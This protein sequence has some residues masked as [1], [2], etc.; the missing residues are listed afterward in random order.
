M[1][2]ISSA[3]R[4]AI[5][6]YLYISPWLIGFLVFAAGPMLVSLFLSLTIYKIITPPD[7]IGVANYVRMFTDDLF[8]R[9]L[10]NTVYYALIFV[11]ISIGGSLTCA[12]LLNQSLWGR[13]L[14]RAIYFL[15]SITPI[16][17]TAFL[18]L[19]IFQ[20]NVG[21]ANY[22]LGEVG[23]AGPRWLDD[24]QWSKPALILISLW[25]SIGGGAMLIFLAGLQGIPHELY[26]S[27]EIDGAGVNSKFWR[28][29]LPLLS[30]SMF[31]NMVLG[32]IGAMQMFTLA[33]VATSGAGQTRP[34]GGPA[35]S[36][37]FYVLNLYNHAFDYW[38]MGYASALAWFFFLILLLLTY[39]QLRLSRSW[40]YYEFERG[41]R[42]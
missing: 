39:W 8:W 7:L 1:M 5:E 25:G 34:A 15:P 2:A 12:L 6:G 16:V 9:S 42:W 3:K 22:L 14:F 26:E 10:W 40:V 38:E 31:F 41:D 37:L 17:A 21:L 35:Y 27:A 13:T 19:W 32:L 24:I 20:P 18:W 11:P 23:I 30:P 33:F 29:T 4:E 28:I 36:T